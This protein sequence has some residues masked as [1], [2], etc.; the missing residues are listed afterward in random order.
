MS[1][2]RRSL[3][4]I[5]LFVFASSASAL[6]ACDG[7]DEAAGS[8]DAATSDATSPDAAVT[9]DG[10]SGDVTTSAD[11]ASDTSTTLDASDASAA[12]DA[13]P[14]VLSGPFAMVH[15]G[16]YTSI[17]VQQSD[18]RYDD[19]GA[20]TQWV[21]SPTIKIERTTAQAFEPYTDPF[22]HAVRWASG[23]VQFVLGGSSGTS[24]LS[25]TWGEHAGVARVPTT[26]PA[27][28]TAT[29]TMVHATK[30]STGLNEVD[31][32]LG[33][34]TAG[35]L[36]VSFGGVSNTRVAFTVTLTMPDGSYE[37]KGNGGFGSGLDGGASGT[38]GDAGFVFVEAPSTTTSDAGSC[39]AG[40]CK[41]TGARIVFAGANAERALLAYS[42]SNTTSANARGGVIV[43]AKQ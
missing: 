19:A 21:A 36:Q 30:T 5:A 4:L 12:S 27:S 28:G 17:D 24:D 15:T 26:V 10:A 31:G 25:G 14:Q 29:Y 2:S 41:T 40:T 43:F 8:P 32:G 6:A 34:V 3:L 38:K 7:D 23:D 20:L 18:V 22:A 16:L 9:S 33:T 35:Q 13:L 37:L 42:F 1:N 11:S 39:D